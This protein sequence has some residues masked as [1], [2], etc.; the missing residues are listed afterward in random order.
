MRDSMARQIA[1][2]DF[3]AKFKDVKKTTDDCYTPEHI[4][5]A[6]VD[7]AVNRYHIGEDTRIIRP[8]YPGGDYRNE[9]YSGDCVVIDNPPFSILK[10][11]CDWYQRN[12]IRF[13][14]FCQGLTVFQLFNGGGGTIG[15]RSVLDSPGMSHILYQRCEDQYRIHHQYGFQ[16][17]RHIG[18]SARHTGT[19]R[20]QCSASHT[21][22]QTALSA[23]SRNIIVARQICDKRIMYRHPRL[24]V[25]QQR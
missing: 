24:G 16:P 12:N 2:E 11:I 21:E 5:R 9:D 14:M 19:R 17:H 4:Y 8:F 23:K 6:V 15:Q 3:V 22:A 20:K 18:G 7:W 25:F 1:Y 10:S 13:L